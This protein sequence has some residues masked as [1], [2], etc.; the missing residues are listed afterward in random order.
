MEK[1]KNPAIVGFM[2]IVIFSSISNIWQQWQTLNDARMRNLKL[3]KEIEEIQVQNRSLVKQIEYATGSAYTQRKMREYL[4]LG[5]T[6]DY[7][8][9]LPDDQS[10]LAVRPEVNEINEI[11][12]I[13]KWW[14]LFAHLR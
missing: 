12:T 3:G 10:N 14:N 2:I 4:G 8:I 6:N 13:I 11:P 5:G 7:W 9:K 1:I